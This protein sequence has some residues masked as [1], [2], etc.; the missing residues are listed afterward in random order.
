MLI[1]NTL[2]QVLVQHVDYRDRCLWAGGAVDKGESPARAAARE[3]AEELRVGA[4]I[5]RCLAV[6][7]VSVDGIGAPAAM[8]SR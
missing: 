6:D 4:T 7:W 5:A 8:C 3:A 1:T 2:G